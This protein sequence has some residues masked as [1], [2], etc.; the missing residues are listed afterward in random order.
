LGE[1]PDFVG[2]GRLPQGTVATLR[3]FMVFGDGAGVGIESVPVERVLFND[4]AGC[5]LWTV[6]GSFAASAVGVLRRG[7]K[8]IDTVYVRC[9]D[10]PVEINPRSQC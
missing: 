2:I 3:E 10:F 6:W 4:G 8:V 7:V 1:A 5:G 9:P